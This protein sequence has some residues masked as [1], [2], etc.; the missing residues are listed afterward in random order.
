[1]LRAQALSFVVVAAC[2]YL[3]G[4]EP[5]LP[6]QPFPESATGTARGTAR[7]LGMELPYVNY[8][9]LEEQKHID[10][11]YLSPTQTM[12]L[13]AFVNGTSYLNSPT[14]CT[15][16]KGESFPFPANLLEINNATFVG[17]ELLADLGVKVQHWVAKFF[18]MGT[19]W[20]ADFFFGIT[21][22]GGPSPKMH[23]A[24]FIGSNPDQSSVV[25]TFTSWDFSPP[26][27]N[28]FSVPDGCQPA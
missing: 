10:F 11:V 1:M 15:F 18:T 12:M 26:P 28:V 2:L 27:D 23:R 4:C 7:M 22:D 8:N 20:Y 9:N 21:N 13:G 25:F 24:V 5:V 17:Y 14:G 3:A 19:Y 16:F 6:R